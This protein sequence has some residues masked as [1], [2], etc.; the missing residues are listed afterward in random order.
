MIENYFNDIV[1]KI[2]INDLLNQWTL[3]TSIYLGTSLYD[4]GIGIPKRGNLYQNEMVKQVYIHISL[5]SDGEIGWGYRKNRFI[6]R[7]SKMNPKYCKII[8]VDYDNYKNMAEYIEDS[9]K[10]G[11]TVMFKDGITLKSKKI[12]L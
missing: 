2:C 5:P 8:P 3:K 4:K 10:T 6:E 7:F 9:I 11:L 12:K 1:Q